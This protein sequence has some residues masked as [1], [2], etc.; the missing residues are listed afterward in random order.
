M[1]SSRRFSRGPKILSQSALRAQLGLPTGRLIGIF[2]R[3]TRWKGQHIALEALRSLPGVHLVI[4][5]EA[6]F[7]EDDRAYR[8]ELQRTAEEPGL[9]GRVHFLGFRSDVTALLQAMDV[10]VHCSVAA[11]PFGR[12]IVESM[13]AGTPVVATR[14][15]GVDE[16]ITDGQDGF[17]VPPGRS[18]GAG[19]GGWQDHSGSG[20][21]RE[22]I[23]GGSCEC[24]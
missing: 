20:L 1:A 4:V 9:Q 14:G 17:L 22:A 21:G 7:T 11:E 15:G 16:I 19:L 18:A 2:G 6:L 23:V 8:E 12:V 5:G 10:V 13:L 3:L 24:P